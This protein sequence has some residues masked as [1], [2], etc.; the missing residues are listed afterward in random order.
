MEHVE[1]IKHEQTRS[2]IVDRG[3]SQCLVVGSY[4]SRFIQLT[5]YFG[6]SGLGLITMPLGVEAFE[7]KTDVAAHGP[8]NLNQNK[9]VLDPTPTVQDSQTTYQY[10]EQSTRSSA[11]LV[12]KRLISGSLW[13]IVMLTKVRSISILGHRCNLVSIVLRSSCSE[14]YGSPCS[15]C[16]IARKWVHG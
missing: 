3:D 8:R 14:P 15:S 16:H 7:A 9:N 4:L 2:D 10:T 13:V 1:N 11:R 5:R 12:L 6:L